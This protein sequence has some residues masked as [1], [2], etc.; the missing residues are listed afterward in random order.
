MGGGEVFMQQLASVFKAL[1]D[2]TRLTIMALLLH[3]GELCVCDFE[4]VLGISQSKSSRHLRYLLNAGL[5][6]NRREGVWMYYRVVERSNTRVK[7]IISSLRR[8]L[9]GREH[10]DL[11]TKLDKW[12]ASKHSASQGLSQQEGTP[13]A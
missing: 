6:K 4:G 1:G 5:V 10:A 13:D 3:H 9:S 12:L 8:L 11:V 7:H 2:E